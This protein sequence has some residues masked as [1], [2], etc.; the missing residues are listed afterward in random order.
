FFYTMH[1][2]LKQANADGSLKPF[3]VP[4]TTGAPDALSITK[5]WS[6]NQLT[7]GELHAPL[8]SH[9]ADL[10]FLDGID[11][12]SAWVDGSPADGAHTAGRTHSLVGTNRQ[13]STIA[14]GISIDQHIANGIN[15]PSPLTVVPSLQLACTVD[16]ND[17]T[18]SQ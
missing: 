7:L 11:M 5:P 8:A 6:T 3:W 15:S 9:Q 18:A 17:I 10:L 13:S 4:T 2:T 12:V 1:G 16:S 14:G